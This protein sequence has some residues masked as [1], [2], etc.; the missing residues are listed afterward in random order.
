MALLVSLV[1]SLVF[2]VILVIVT[3]AVEIDR[4]PDGPGERARALA[5]V[6]RE[7]KRLVPRLSTA[8]MAHFRKP[9]GAKA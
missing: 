7:G 6:A 4:L 2:I 1:V 8:G 5:R 9:K 3:L